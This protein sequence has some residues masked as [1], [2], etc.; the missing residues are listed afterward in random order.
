LKYNLY[1][2]WE[3]LDNESFYI[4]LED[5]KYFKNHIEKYK[6]K[7]EL[8]FKSIADWE[9]R[10][11]FFDI[12]DRK[13]FVFA[14]LALLKLKAKIVLIPNEI[15]SEDYIYKGGMFLSD[16]KKLDEGLFLNDDL[17]ITIGKNFNIDDLEPVN[18]D[19]TVIYLY[20]SGSTG[21]SKLINKKAV[22]L[23]SEVK[24][25]KRIL[26]INNEDIFY[27]TPPL[28]HI[29]GFLF[30][31]LLPLY[32]SAKIVLDYNF[33]PE[34][35]ADFVKKREINYFVSIPSYYRLFVD[36]NLINCFSNCKNLF[37]S[38][39]PLPLDVS[40]KFYEL[41]IKITEIYGSTETGGVAYRTSAI[42]QEWKMFSYVK[43]VEEPSGYIDS[44][45]SQ[46]KIVEL[47][48][49]SP[50]ISVNYDINKGFNTGDVVQLSTDGKF[51]LLGRNTRFVKISGKRIDLNYVLI[52]VKDCLSE[53]T[54]EI[55]KE[56]KLYIGLHQNKIFVIYEDPF[57]KDIKDIKND[58]KKH[59]PSYAVPRLYI[60]SAIPKNNMG[61]INKVK[62]DQILKNAIL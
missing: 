8:N 49:L 7:L 42:S 24:E 46:K 15:K 30:G 40:A 43:I 58:L 56:E 18:I 9:N 35:I 1:S 48:L 41:N 44:D 20:T 14:F 39:A 51:I 5:K 26:G 61:K 25:L 45:D 57:P 33:T 60:N 31:L 32:C 54:G 55:I 37:S 50:A 59:L 53:I 34:S 11:V 28:Y 38:S 23:I 2:L 62:I 21:K 13:L 17:S 16:N 4:E 10:K 3:D 6:N 27:F 36:L 52:K 47:R 29:Y 12:K 22:N 19:D